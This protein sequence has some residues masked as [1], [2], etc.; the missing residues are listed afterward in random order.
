MCGRQ[1]RDSA[2]AKD[3]CESLRS[4]ITRRPLCLLKCPFPRGP[5]WESVEWEMPEGGG[6]PWRWGGRSTEGVQ[7]NK[8]TAD[9]HV[10]A[11][12]TELG[13][14]SRNP[15]KAARQEDFTPGTHVVPGTLCLLTLSPPEI[16]AHLVIAFFQGLWWRWCHP[17]RGLFGYT[18]GGHAPRGACC[19][20]WLLI[21]RGSRFHTCA[22]CFGACCLTSLCLH[23]CILL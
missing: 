7:G 10:G 3:E 18:G 21:A 4:F 20:G 15:D 16:P 1:G 23:T 12:G 13:C 11:G 9:Q 2:D 14:V 5:G 17:L 22:V 8:T 6:L 19:K